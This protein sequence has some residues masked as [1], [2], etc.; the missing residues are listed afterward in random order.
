[1]LDGPYSLHS[2]LYFKFINN[3]LSKK[4]IVVNGDGTNTRDY[5][6]FQIYVMQYINQLKIQMEQKFIMLELERKLQSKNF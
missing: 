2:K 4:A 1:M 6:S 3:I 5:L